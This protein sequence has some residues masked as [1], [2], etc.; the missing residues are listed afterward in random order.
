MNTTS[1]N[2]VGVLFMAG[3]IASTTAFAASHRKPATNAG[4]SAG[5]AN[6]K[7]VI[8]ITGL[9]DAKPNIKGDLSLTP[10]ALV[11][12]NADINAPISLNRI[13]AVTAGFEKTEKG[14][15][16]GRVGRT[17]IPFGGAE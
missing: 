6:V 2:R 15:T 5:D 14:G 16:A 9:I 8:H 3:L 17:V 13:I 12:S 10:N 11:F 4:L 7:G 1:F